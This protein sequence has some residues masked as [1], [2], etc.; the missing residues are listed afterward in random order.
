MY[1]RTD[2]L[3]QTLFILHNDF[4]MQI[5]EYGL[6]H[7]LAEE[8]GG[9]LVG[10]FVPRFVAHRRNGTGRNTL[11][12]ILIVQLKEKVK[13]EYIRICDAYVHR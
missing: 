7:R 1:V 13:K 8:V 12:E 9:E 5:A 11:P 2:K 10:H 3:S 6:H 4:L